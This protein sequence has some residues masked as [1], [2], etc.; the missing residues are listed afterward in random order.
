V[1]RGTACSPGV[2][3]RLI[4]L[5]SFTVAGAAGRAEDWPTYMHDAARSGVSGE[6]LK[7]P[8]DALWTYVP[9]A[10]PEPAWPSPQVGWGELPK[11]DFDCAIH[12]AMAG[13]AVY[14]GS[15]VD[16]GV[17][18][19]DAQTG[20][21]R[22]TFFTEGPVRLAPTVADGGQRRQRPNLRR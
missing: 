6:S 2:L 5:A 12:V 16:N 21:R 9:P 22:W 13:D 1:N 3:R 4:L 17:H 11:L 14:F 10:E 8:L 18:A 7:L 20:Q 19:L 15:A